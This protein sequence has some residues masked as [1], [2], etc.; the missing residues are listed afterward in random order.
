LKLIDK[1]RTDIKIAM[2]N[3][4]VF[5]R[6]TL[7]LLN[8][9]M[10]QIE[11]DERRE[12]SDEDVLKILQKQIKQREDVAIQ[13][14]EANR[15]DLYDKEIGESN[16]FKEYLPKQLSDDE[17]KSEIKQIIDSVGATSLK[18]MG[19]VMGVATK[20]LAGKSDGKRINQ[21]VKEILG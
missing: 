13:Y 18:D 7:R 2:K 14:K 15:I 3:K 19:K 20:K 10:K 6:D 17:L 16:I 5:R 21:C 9:A 4:D 8:S 12:L 1:I 11:I